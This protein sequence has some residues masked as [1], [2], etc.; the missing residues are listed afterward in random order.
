MARVEAPDL[1]IADEASTYRHADRKWPLAGL[2]CEPPPNPPRPGAVNF[3]PLPGPAEPKRACFMEFPPLASMIPPIAG[4]VLRV[5]VAPEAGDTVPRGEVSD[6]IAPTL[7]ARIEGGEA[8]PANTRIDPT[9]LSLPDPEAFRSVLRSA[10]DARLA[11]VVQAVLIELA[12]RQVQFPR[13]T[14]DAVHE[15]Y[16]RRRHAVA[17]PP[18]DERG[19]VLCE[20][21]AAA[22][23]TGGRGMKAAI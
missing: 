6:S 1:A 15:L 22:L 5:Y 13:T 19:A 9:C 17:S 7:G 4:P 8:L 2:S 20:P 21:R 23:R 10:S 12:R 3:R 16:R 11:D 18:S 14:F